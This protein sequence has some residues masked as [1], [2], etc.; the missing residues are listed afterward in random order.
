LGF[1]GSLVWIDLGLIEVNFG[2]LGFV[3]IGLS[4]FF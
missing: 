4:C 1:F 2:V 3:W